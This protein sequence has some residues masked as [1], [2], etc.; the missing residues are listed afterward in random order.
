MRDK[1]IAI[2]QEVQ[3]CGRKAI[4]ETETI[5]VQNEALADYL[6][7]NGIGDITAEK[8]RA[9]VAEEALEIA[10]EVFYCTVNNKEESDEKSVIRLIDY[11]KEQAAERLEEK[12]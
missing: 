7:A 10:C 2:I 3:G 8:H 4:S 12:K 5:V 11:F 1:L 9:D 6:I